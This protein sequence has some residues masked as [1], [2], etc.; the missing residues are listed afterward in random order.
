MLKLK[1]DNTIQVQFIT[2]PNCPECIQAKQILKEAKSKFHNIVVK[3]YDVIGLKG[4]ELAVKY[5]I[6]ANPGIVINDKLF[7]VGFLNKEKLFQKIKDIS[8]THF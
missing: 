1:A 4:L 7:S 3:E 6:M 5:S 2:S 8:L